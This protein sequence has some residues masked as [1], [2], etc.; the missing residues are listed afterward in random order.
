VLGFHI[1]PTDSENEE[2][3]EDQ[4]LEIDRMDALLSDLLVLARLDAGGLEV[5]DKPFD[6]T[7]VAAETA[8]RFPAGVA[9]EGLSRPRPCP[10]GI[11]HPSSSKLRDPGG[12]A[13]LVAPPTVR[14]LMTSSMLCH[15]LVSLAMCGAKCRAIPIYRYLLNQSR[16]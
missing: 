4:L 1:A 7:S 12:A 3:V 15:L 8:G 5:E 14:W 16:V 9:E 10:R 6:L 13:F 2:I 11:D